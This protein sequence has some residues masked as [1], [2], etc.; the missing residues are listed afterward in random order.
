MIQRRRE[1]LVRAFPDY[2]DHEQRAGRRLW[3]QRLPA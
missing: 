1:A 2:P 3:I